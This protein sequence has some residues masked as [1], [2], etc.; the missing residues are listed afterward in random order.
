MPPVS[1]NDLAH[2]LEHTREL[3]ED[4]RGGRVFITGGT[5]FFGCWL[6]ESFGYANDRLRLGAN[7][8]VL[9]RGASSFHRKVPHIAARP[10]IELVEGNVVDFA[11]PAGE[12]SH[13]IH[14]ATET[15]S[16][17]AVVDPVVMFDA[18]L[19]ATR[20]VMDFVKECGAKKALF[21]SSGAAYG[22][23]PSELTHV[24]ESYLGGPRRWM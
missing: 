3:W 16:S 5:G 7:A 12:F 18:N 15:S 20:R 21:T 11:F 9:T 14:A 23:Q 1:P 19:E 6:L 13:V 2:V 8:A 17:G 10:D 4:L 24:P 22:S